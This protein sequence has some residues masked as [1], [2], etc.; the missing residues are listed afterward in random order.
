MFG[1]LCVY[2]R[3]TVGGGSDVR[4]AIFSEPEAAELKASRHKT[5]TAHTYGAHWTQSGVDDAI[6][7]FKNHFGI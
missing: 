3:L 4:W 2:Q 6:E 1:Y 5:A 7:S